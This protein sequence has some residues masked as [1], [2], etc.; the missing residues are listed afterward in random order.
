[1]RRT[2]VDAIK[3][4]ETFMDRESRRKT[5]LKWKWPERLVEAGSCEA[6]MYT[7]DK[8]REEGDFVDYKHVAEGPQVLY[9]RE[10]FLRDYDGND[11]ESCGEVVELVHEMPDTIA[12][13]APILGIQC[14]LYEQDEDGE[15]YLPNGDENLYQIDISGAKLG[16]AKHPETGET[17]LVVYTESGGVLC[18]ITGTKLDVLKDGIVG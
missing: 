15:S 1:M 7:S 9:V 14:R 8:W 17:F 16:A 3:L 13:L 18:M 4:R 2:E 12:M 10:G 6:V 5:K 11:L